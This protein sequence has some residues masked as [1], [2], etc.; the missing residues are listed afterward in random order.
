MQPATDNPLPGSVQNSVPDEMTNYL[1]IIPDELSPLERAILDVTV[2]QLVNHGYV[3]VADVQ[4]H[5]IEDRDGIRY[6]PF[7]AGI[8][9]R[10]GSMNSVVVFHDPD[11]ETTARICYPGAHIMI[12]NPA[13]AESDDVPVSNREMLRRAA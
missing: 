8:M 9:P 11:F 1:F 4:Q 12:L 3:Y 13:D 10:F 2:R 6:M 7:R 5:V